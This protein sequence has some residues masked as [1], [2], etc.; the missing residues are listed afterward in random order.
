MTV[1]FSFRPLDLH[2]QQTA[3]AWTLPLSFAT[4]FGSLQSAG[5]TRVGTLYLGPGVYRLLD[6]VTVIPETVELFFSPGAVLR[7]PPGS[8]LVVRGP[9]VADPSRIF[10]L[11][12]D[13]AGGPRGR[14]RLHQTAL[15]EVFPELSA[16]HILL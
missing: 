2:N 5:G 11:G 10:E 6:G 15:S 13:P 16:A 7:V 14:V 8:E 3:P 12:Y 9:I 1:D 4:L